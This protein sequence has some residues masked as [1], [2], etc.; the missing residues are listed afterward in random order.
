[1]AKMQMEAEVA[2]KQGNVATSMKVTQQAKK[3]LQKMSS[4]R[5]E[6]AL[7]KNAT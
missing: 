3:K 7:P 4:Q 1:M 2:I 6:K 5:K